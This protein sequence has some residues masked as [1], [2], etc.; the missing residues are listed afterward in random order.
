[1]QLTILSTQQW[2]KSSY[3][4]NFA[5]FQPINSTYHFHHK[6]GV[7]NSVLRPSKQGLLYL[8]MPHLQAFFGIQFCTFDSNTTDSTCVQIQ[9]ISPQNYGYLDNIF[10]V[11]IPF[12]QPFPTKSWMVL[13][14]HHT[15]CATAYGTITFFHYFS[16]IIFFHLFRF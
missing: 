7:N 2:A 6:L 13:I 4:L 11:L 16:I 5:H 10:T 8:G 14:L 3:P 15:N 1:M 9:I 12:V